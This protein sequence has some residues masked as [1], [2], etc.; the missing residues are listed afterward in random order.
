MNSP[1]FVN[2]PA[3]SFAR[4]KYFP[5]RRLSLAEEL[6][7]RAHTIALRPH[8]DPKRR[9]RAFPWN[10]DEPYYSKLDE[11]VYSQLSEASWWSSQG[12][13]ERSRICRRAV[14]APRG[15]WERWRKRRGAPLPLSSRDRKQNPFD[16]RDCA[17]VAGILECRSRW[18]ASWV[19]RLRRQKL[20]LRTSRENSNKWHFPYP[21]NLIEWYDIL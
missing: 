21:T 11:E 18:K 4:W 20:L 2:H 8:K 15:Q 7:T 9:C 16:R 13:Q 1:Y 19:Y 6:S 14:V 17:L 10:S 3:H 12:F 5:E